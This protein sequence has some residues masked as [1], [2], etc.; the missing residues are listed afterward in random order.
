MNYYW[1]DLNL[2][3]PSLLNCKISNKN[4]NI[5]KFKKLFEDAINY[6]NHV[7]DLDLEIEQISRFIYIG[8]DQFRMLR[9]FQEMKKTQQAAHRYQ[10][11]NILGILEAF[12]SY[13]SDEL[14][15][16]SLPYRQ[17][18]DYVLI[19]LQG[20]SKLLIRVVTCA[21]K[22]AK[23][24]LGYIR[25]GSFYI[26]GS[27]FVSSLGKIWDISRSMCRLSVNLFNNLINFRDQFKFNDKI[28]WDA[29]NCSFPNQL[30]EWLGCEYNECIANETYDYKMLTSEVEI[31][32]LLSNRSNSLNIFGAIKKGISS[33]AVEE[34]SSNLLGIA[35]ESEIED[36][37]P[38][39]RNKIKT[40]DD[41]VHSISNIKSKDHVKKF[42][43][44]EDRFR[45]VNGQNS[46]TI[47]K[48]KNKAWKKFKN[49]LNTK[50]QIMQ[51]SSLMEYFH[52]N[53]NEF[54]Q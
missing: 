51:E 2:A 30:D 15:S 27:I 1:N 25:A 28:E 3:M 49:D 52:D 54:I 46:L 20:L 13:V 35:I 6:F 8:R 41:Y 7:D 40:E 23:F 24:F 21:K 29:N 37:T 38:I 53:L 19:K 12:N 18:L 16:I 5:D 14:K 22:S 10:R 48:V 32:N 11:M 31:N 36:Y 39:A 34:V 47:K 45:K 33:D 26:K 42:I 43:T 4:F 50:I 9:G 17:S 44:T